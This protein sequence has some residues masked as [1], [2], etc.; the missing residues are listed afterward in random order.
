MACYGYRAFALYSILSITA[1]WFPI[2]I[3]VVTTL[4]WIFWLVLGIRW[5]KV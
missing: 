1:L 2:A 4:S 3:V 5:K